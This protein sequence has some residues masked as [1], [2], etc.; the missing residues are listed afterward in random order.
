[1]ASVP[2]YSHISCSLAPSPLFSLVFLGAAYSDTRELRKP[3]ACVDFAA[4]AVIAVP[5]E[6]EF[7]G[8]PDQA[9]QPQPA[10]ILPA[11]TGDPPPPGVTSPSGY[12]DR[13]VV[14]LNW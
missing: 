14:A 6:I 7:G 1:M 12:S 3:F 11:L 4:S 8:Q 5:A 2:L 9:D 13:L 10:I